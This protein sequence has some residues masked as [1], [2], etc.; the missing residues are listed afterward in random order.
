MTR[1]NDNRWL[2]LYDRATDGRLAGLNDDVFDK[3]V[4]CFTDRPSC[5]FMRSVVVV[6]PVN[7]WTLEVRGSILAVVSMDRWT[8]E[9]RRSTATVLPMNRWTLEVRGSIVVVVPMDRWT[10][11]TR[12]STAVVLLMNQWAWVQLNPYV[13]P[14]DR[15][16]FNDATWLFAYPWDRW[17]PGG[18]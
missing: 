7:R 15:W 3:L 13:R 17:S 4:M 14:S 8:L 18:Q 12:R 1:L 9:I 6:L 5:V 16:S 11:E 2:K 10:L